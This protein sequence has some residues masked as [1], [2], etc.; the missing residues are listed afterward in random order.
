MLLSYGHTSTKLRHS[1]VPH[2]DVLSAILYL[3]PHTTADG[4][5]TVCGA[6]VTDGCFVG[7]LY[8]AG[9]GTFDNV[10]AA[11]IRRT[12]EFFDDPPA[13]VE[14]VARDIA[15]VESRAAKLGLLPAVRLNGTSDL[16]W[17]LQRHGG[18]SL[19]DRFPSVQFWDYT[20]RARTADAYA[21]GD[22]P[23]NY[24][25]T[26]S[27]SELTRDADISRMVGSGCNTAVVFDTKRGQPLPTAYRSTDALLHPILDGDTH[28]YRWRDMRG[29]Y[30]V[31]LR[32]K[33]PAI[34][35]RTGFV[36]DAS[37]HVV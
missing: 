7:C 15:R 2:P 25:V 33:G 18:E 10:S 24:H 26:W 35:D 23:P 21:S 27:R 19:M 17:Y 11:R 29:G 4:R 5:R 22:L 6:E 16:P 30:I 13:F 37:R 32:A 12:L 1:E 9:R 8:G 3:A 31:G 28:D 34:G 36:V 14:S 20:K